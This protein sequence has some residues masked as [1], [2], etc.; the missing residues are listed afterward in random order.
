MKNKKS[1]LQSEADTLW[2]QVAFTGKCEV[3]GRPSNQVHHYYYKGNYGHMR[4]DLDNAINI[5]M[6]C[7]FTIHHKDPKQN[8][9]I[10][11]AKRGKEW[12]DKLEARSKVRL[13]SFKTVKYYEDTISNL[14]L[15]LL[16]KQKLTII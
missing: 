6:G 9:K 8:E 10:I 15:K 14:K 12:A 3:C 5:C 1:Q 13:S 2:Y 11:E 7:H 16:D 4:Y